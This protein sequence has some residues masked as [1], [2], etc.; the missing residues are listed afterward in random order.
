[1]QHRQS[2]LTPVCNFREETQ[3]SEK[4]VFVDF[5]SIIK[6]TAISHSYIYYFHMKEKH[7][8]VTFVLLRSCEVVQ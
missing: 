4:H 6:S 5:D 7:F 1:M 2:S 8:T 3:C